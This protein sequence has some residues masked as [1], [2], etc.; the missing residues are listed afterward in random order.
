MRPALTHSLHAFAH[1]LG[2]DVVRFPG[3][4]TSLARRIALVRHFAVDL[5]L[6]VGANEGQYAQE[7]RNLGYIGSI[8]SFEPL[9]DP[10]RRLQHRARNDPGWT[11]VN[12]ALGDFDG[13]ATMHVAGNSVS[14]SM[15][16]ML[17]MHEQAA[18]GSAYIADV[19]VTV[20]RL[21]GL[22]GHYLQ[23]AKRPF[24]KIDAQGFERRVLAGAD[25]A[26]PCIIGL[27]LELSLE[28][29]YA[30]GTLLED[31]LTLTRQAGFSLLG[32]EPGFSDPRSGRLLQADGIF[33]RL[34][35]P[36]PDVQATQ[37]SVL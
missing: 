16:E 19:P 32:I 13:E 34:P 31:M 11:A 26:L 22:A 23:A 7:M 1:R 24:L 6:D 18:P 10:F 5:I 4:R 9:P 37:D 35:Q 29:L 2:V 33:F 8:I 12:L 28:P 30:D 3:A 17:P 21:D 20:R 14:S 36:Q 27:Q 15:L 25:E